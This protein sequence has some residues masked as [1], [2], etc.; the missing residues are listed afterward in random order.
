M[1]GFVARNGQI[2]GGP[3]GLDGT[4]R[5]ALGKNIEGHAVSSSVSG[6]VVC[7]LRVIDDDGTSSKN[8]STYPAPRTIKEWVVIADTRYLKNIF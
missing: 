6:I 5:W 8:E 2:S 3:D 4:V 7:L 1:G